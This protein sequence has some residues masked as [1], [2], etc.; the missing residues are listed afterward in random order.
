MPLHI[1]EENNDLVKDMVGLTPGQSAAPLIF[2]GQ[3]VPYPTSARTG[4][5]LDGD[6]TDSEIFWDVENIRFDPDGLCSAPEFTLQP[7]TYVIEINLLLAGTTGASIAF[8][9]E[10]WGFIPTY[11]EPAVPAGNNASTTARIYQEVSS[12]TTFKLASFID[13]TIYLAFVDNENDLAQNSIAIY[14][15]R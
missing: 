7:G 10:N 9:D 3:L 15:I 4:T 14:K 11:T 2:L 6:V 13:D 1:T 8:Y 5:P 12:A